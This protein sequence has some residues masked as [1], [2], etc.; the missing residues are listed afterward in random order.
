MNRFTPFALL[1]AG[2]LAVGFVGTGCQKDDKDHDKSANKKVDSGKTLWARLGGEKAVT[3]V[4]DD[5]VGRAASNPKVNFFR[6]NVPGVTEWKPTDAE[7]AR[8]KRLLVEFISSASGG[9]L[10]YTGRSMESSHRGMKI[11]N[12]EFDA[13]AGDLS[14]SLD[15]FKVPKKEKDELMAAVGGTRGTIVGK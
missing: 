13:I 9:P 7:V 1:I 14:A 4:V 11:T 5:F 3:A 8:L 12:A 10:K 15:K 6:K 2:A